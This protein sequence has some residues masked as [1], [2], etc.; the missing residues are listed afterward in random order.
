LFAVDN[1]ETVNQRFADRLTD[2]GKVIYVANRQNMGVARGLNIGAQ[3]ALEHGCDFLL[4]MDQDSRATPGLVGMMLDCL[5][6]IDIQS[7]GIISPFHATRPGE[8][9]EGKEL[10]QDLLTVM[11][12]GNLLQLKAYKTVGPFMDELFIDFID[13][14]YCLRL[15]KA[16]FRVILANRAIL[17]HQVGT[18]M[19]FSFFSR[20]LYLT[21][22]DPLRKYYKTRNRFF[23]R[24][25][26][27]TAYP[28]FC[29]AD[30]LRFLL[31]LLRLLL[32]ER[33]KIKKISMIFKGYRDYR[34]GKLG[35]FKADNGVEPR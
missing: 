21:S 22:H 14:E 17:R 30:R 28:R 2:A 9:P 11:T 24:E 6:R 15:Q 34:R 8:Q 1:S 3:L 19:K 5:G 26:Y 4:T 20:A 13:I 18:K 33:E 10:Y 32:F 35:K 27:K 16:G 12:S 31:E 25:R 23:V 29:R 7:V